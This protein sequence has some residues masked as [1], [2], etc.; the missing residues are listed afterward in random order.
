MNKHNKK[1][2]KIAA[3]LSINIIIIAVISLVVLAVL[4]FI[5]SSKS[6]IFTKSTS[7][8]CKAQGGRCITPPGQKC[9]GSEYIIYTKGCESIGDSGEKLQ[10]CCIKYESE[11]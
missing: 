6:Q 4:I 3:E 2:K 7:Q 10:A 8:P 9:E 5:F 1:I 11:K